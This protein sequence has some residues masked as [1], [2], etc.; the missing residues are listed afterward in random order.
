MI[1]GSSLGRTGRPHRTPR[2]RTTSSGLA[3]TP[4]SST[5]AVG[6][7][8]ARAITHSGSYQLRPLHRRDLPGNLFRA[9]T[10]S[11][12]STAQTALGRGPGRVGR[13]VHRRANLTSY[14]DEV[15]VRE[16]PPRDPPFQIV[17]L[18]TQMWVSS[19]DD[20]A[21][22]A[23]VQVRVPRQEPIAGPAVSLFGTDADGGG[24]VVL[25][26]TSAALTDGRRRRGRSAD[27]NGRPEVTVGAIAAC[28]RVA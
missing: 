5:G 20:D 8:K 24:L 14:L 16:D 21:F 13:S 12:S 26:R 1:A 2:T 6:W 22:I 28:E 3:S 7:T 10:T 19:I 17:N 11:T 18:P 4:R 15:R 9:S 23:T 25:T 27:G